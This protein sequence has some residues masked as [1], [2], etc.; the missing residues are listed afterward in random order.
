[1]DNDI[2]FHTAFMYD[3]I[4]Y[5]HFFKP[6]KNVKV[7]LISRPYKKQAGQIWFGGYSLLTP[8]PIDDTAND[9]NVDNINFHL[10]TSSYVAS[11]LSIC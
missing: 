11:P 2:C 3:Q 4:V 9:D 5:I 10:L 6:L 8:C 7:I 1:M